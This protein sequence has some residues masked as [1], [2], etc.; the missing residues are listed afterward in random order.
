[1]SCIVVSFFS[2]Y[3]CCLHMLQLTLHSRVMGAAVNPE[4]L[5]QVRAMRSRRVTTR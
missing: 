3:R 1:M 5:T 2:H 4:P